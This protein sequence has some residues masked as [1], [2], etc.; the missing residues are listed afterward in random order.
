MSLLLH[1]GHLINHQRSSILGQAWKQESNGAGVL[2]WLRCLANSMLS[3]AML[4]CKT[5]SAVHEPS[6]RSLVPTISVCNLSCA[7]LQLLPNKLQD[8]IR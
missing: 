7:S 8:H 3:P 1:G 5:S 2:R 4:C 6:L